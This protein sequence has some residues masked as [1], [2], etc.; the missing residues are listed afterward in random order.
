MAAL[1][2]IILSG[3]VKPIEIIYQTDEQIETAATPVSTMTPTPAPTPSVIPTRTPSSGTS[4]SP[5]AGPDVPEKADDYSA[6]VGDWIYS[7]TATTRFEVCTQGGSAIRILEIDG[8]HIEGNIFTVSD[9]PGNREAYVEFEGTIED[10]MF[11]YTFD[12]DG[13]SN[14]GHF[15]IFLGKDNIYM[16]I[17][18]EISDDNNTGWNLGYGDYT[19]VRAEKIE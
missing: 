8:D 2:L 6:Y 10:H 7:D 9:A 19:Y 13:W 12:D 17:D 11:E 1:L 18:T 4:A 15:T 3:C 16:A 5:P 14:H